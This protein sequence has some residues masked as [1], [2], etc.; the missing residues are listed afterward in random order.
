MV[1]VLVHSLGLGLGF[2]HAGLALHFLQSKTDEKKKKPSKEHL[3]F[4]I[5]IKWYEVQTSFI[6]RINAECF[7]INWSSKFT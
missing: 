1:Y 7:A 2:I 5:T 3:Q 6:L 4:W